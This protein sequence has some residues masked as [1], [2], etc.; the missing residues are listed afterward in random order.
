MIRVF[1]ADDHTLVRQGIKRI[2]Q[3]E[4]DMQVVGE[5]ADSYAALRAIGELA[6]DVMVLDLSMPGPGGLEVL[7]ELREKRIKPPVL[8]VSMHPEARFAIRAF[9]LGAAGYMTKERAAEELVLAIRRICGGGKYVTPEVADLLACCWQ[10]ENVLPH[11]KLSPR[12]LSVFQALAAGQRVAEIAG[13]LGVTAPTVYTYRARI[14]EKMNFRSNA[15][16]V[17][18]AATHSLLD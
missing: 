2:L 10:D 7:A 6:I 5:A 14:F 1:L 13:S 3:G 4:P 15:E 9:R 18:Y 17:R 11:E 16:L 12:E 8:V